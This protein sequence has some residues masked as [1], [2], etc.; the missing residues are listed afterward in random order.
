MTS[1]T[2]SL[3]TF[4]ALNRSRYLEALKTGRSQDWTI[5]VGNEAGGMCFLFH[6]KKAPE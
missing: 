2:A 5:V 4:L 3:S 6:L 1:Q